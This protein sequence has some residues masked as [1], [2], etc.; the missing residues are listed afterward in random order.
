MNRRGFTLIELLIV[1][2]I[3]AIAVSVLI[4]G[5]SGRVTVCVEGYRMFVSPNGTIQQ[6]FDDQGRGVRCQPDKESE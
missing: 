3:I 5:R 2:A 1:V 4:S 6:L